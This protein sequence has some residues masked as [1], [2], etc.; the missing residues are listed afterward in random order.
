LLFVQHLGRRRRSCG[1]SGGGGGGGGGHRLH[2]VLYVCYSYRQY[3]NL[4]LYDR[5]T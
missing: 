2:V 4:L 3:D 5:V 1:S